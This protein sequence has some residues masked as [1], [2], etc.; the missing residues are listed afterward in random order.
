MN[1]PTIEI[2]SVHGLKETFVVSPNGTVDTTQ[3]HTNRST[4]APNEQQDEPKI[5]RRTK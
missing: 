4:A 5:E 2:Q 1:L 3:Q